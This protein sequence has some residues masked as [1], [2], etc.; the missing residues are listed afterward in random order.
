[1]GLPCFVLV[2][3]VYNFTL[4]AL[5]ALVYIGC[6]G[7]IGWARAQ[8]GPVLVGPGR[9]PGSHWFRPPRNSSNR[10]GGFSITKESQMG[11]AGR[12]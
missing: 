1:M 7:Y 2:A 3:L 8:P 12:N 5:V 10:L 11:V 4:V 9:G 6:I